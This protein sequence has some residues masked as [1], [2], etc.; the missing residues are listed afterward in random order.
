MQ[1]GIQINRQL[2][3]IGYRQLGYRYQFIGIV[4]VFLLLLAPMAHT[5]QCVVYSSYITRQI[6]DQCVVW[7]VV[8]TIR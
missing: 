4:I 1:K 3:I 6:M 2:S 7:R 5:N 8:F